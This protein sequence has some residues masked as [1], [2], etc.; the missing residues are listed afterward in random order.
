[1]DLTNHW[2][3]VRVDMDKWKVL[4]EEG[5]LYTE[6]LGPCIG[7]AVAFGNWAGIIHSSYPPYDLEDIGEL[8]AEA[9]RV[10]PQTRLIELRPVLC[11]SDPACDDDSI[12]CYEDNVLRARSTIIEVLRSEGFGDPI[13]HWSEANETAAI[14]ADLCSLR[15]KVEV[16]YKEFV[17]PIMQ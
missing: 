17:Y 14:F 12:E 4:S 11:G 13:I 10:I 1:M 5:V 6:G 16:E 8:L 3:P 7:L 9:K 15:I 2:N